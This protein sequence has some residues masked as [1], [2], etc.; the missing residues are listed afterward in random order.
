MVL[1]LIKVAAME[2]ALLILVQMARRTLEVACLRGVT[3][4]QPRGYHG[5]QERNTVHITL[6]IFCKET[7]LLARSIK[8]WGGTKLACTRPVFWLGT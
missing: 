2:T 4:D 6:P 1:Q 8:W 5:L 3:T 7:S